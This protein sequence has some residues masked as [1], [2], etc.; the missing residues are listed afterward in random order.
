MFRRLRRQRLYDGRRRY[1]LLLAC[2][3]AVSGASYYFYAEIRPTVIFGLRDDYARAI[4][5]QE[6][7]VGL[8][9]LKAKECGRCHQEIYEEWKTSIHAH[10]YK[11]PFFPA[12]WK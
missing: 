11:D 10:A 8:E 4:P 5:F 1:G 7:P 3:L 12:F 2:L 9:S 6:I